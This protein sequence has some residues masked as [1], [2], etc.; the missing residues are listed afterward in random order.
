MGVMSWLLLVWSG[1]VN[2]IEPGSH[3]IPISER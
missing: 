1:V 3:A 2:P